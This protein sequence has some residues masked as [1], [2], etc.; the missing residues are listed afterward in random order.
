MATT[1]RRTGIGVVGD[2]PWG[3]HFCH[4]AETKDDLRET[5][6]AYFKAGL[7]DDEFLHVRA[8]H[9]GRDVGRGAT[10]PARS[11]PARVRRSIEMFR[12]REW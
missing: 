1:L 6:V 4:F 10:C 12:A 2:M 5:V 11:R 8:P 3:S 9:E 7:E